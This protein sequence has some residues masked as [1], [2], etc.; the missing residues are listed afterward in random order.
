MIL[1]HDAN[2]RQYESLKLDD[3]QAIGQ[4]L[5]NMGEEYIAFFNCGQDGG[6]SRLHKHMQLIPKPKSSFAAFLDTEG[7]IEPDVPFQ[8]FHHRFNDALIYPTELL[9]IY[10]K[11]LWE[12]TE[13]GKGLFEHADSLPAGAAVPHNVLVTNRWMVV[14]PRRQAGVDK[15]AG[16]N[17]IGMIGVI[18]VASSEEIGIWEQIGPAN[19]LRKLGVPNTRWCY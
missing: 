8:W 11:L 14:I 16:A 18:P 1:T 5:V 6:C 7:G 12:A 2:K 13:V 9:F 19:V 15:V 3:W 17:A 10:Q 4:V